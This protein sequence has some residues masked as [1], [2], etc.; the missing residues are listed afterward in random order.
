[1]FLAGGH[2]IHLCDISLVIQ[3]PKTDQSIGLLRIMGEHALQRRD[4]NVRVA[5]QD[6][7]PFAPLSIP[8]VS[9]TNVSSVWTYAP[10]GYVDLYKVC[11]G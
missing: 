2:C 5:Y 7:C 8:S 10:L 1:M 4:P 3:L 11:T 9:D 6:G